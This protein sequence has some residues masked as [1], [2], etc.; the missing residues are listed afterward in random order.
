MS[1]KIPH[2]VTGQPG[3]TV[4]LNA[5]VDVVNEQSDLIA[6]LREELERKADKRTPKTTAK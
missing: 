3:Y 6:Q 1:D 2:F 4:K 5:L